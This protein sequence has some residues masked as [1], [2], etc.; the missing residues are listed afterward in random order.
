MTAQATFPSMPPGPGEGDA[1]MQERWARELA[2]LGEEAH[3]LRAA[4]A[5]DRKSVV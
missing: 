3:R 2:V 4:Y 1:R 5:V